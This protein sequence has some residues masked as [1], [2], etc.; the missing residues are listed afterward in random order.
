MTRE[1]QVTDKL[2]EPSNYIIW[3]RCVDD[4]II[5]PQD[6]TV[7][8]TVYGSNSFPVDII[9]IPVQVS[10]DISLTLDTFI[11]D[12]CRT[13]YYEECRMIAYVPTSQKAVFQIQTSFGDSITSLPSGFGPLLKLRYTVVG[14]PESA[15]QTPVLL[16]G[17]GTYEP[18]L[19]GDLYQY[20]PGVK[21]GAVVY[22]GCCWGITA[23]VDNGSD[24][25]IDISD[26]A[27]L[28]DYMFTG[29]PPPECE[30]EANIE[31]VGGID[32][33]DLVYLV[34]YMFTEGPAPPACPW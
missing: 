32:I 27:Y 25:V 17:Y 18:Q 33:S 31:S 16:D 28:V 22:N 20:R 10:G 15:C 19:T 2:K 34:D 29:G 13:D 21:A 11:T 12:G 7:E 14:R 30:D 24:Q 9:T 23:N 26:L 6:T 5:G 3:Q 1:R 8:V 4:I